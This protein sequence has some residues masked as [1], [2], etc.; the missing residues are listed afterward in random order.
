ML[1]IKQVRGA[2]IGEFTYYKEAVMVKCFSMLELSCGVADP[3][4]FIS[5]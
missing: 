3:V 1:L 5:A 4:F 2:L